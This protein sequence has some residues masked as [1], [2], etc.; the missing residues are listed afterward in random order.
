MG[1][2]KLLGEYTAHFPNALAKLIQAA[3]DDYEAKSLTFK[4]IEKRA[5]IFFIVR[6]GQHVGLVET[7][8][9]NDEELCYSMVQ[10]PLFFARKIS[11]AAALTPSLGRG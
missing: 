3:P 9:Y 6:S 8:G 7:Q 4:E 11:T 10:K 5:D 2:D 1:T